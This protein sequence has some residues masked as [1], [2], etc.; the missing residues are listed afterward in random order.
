MK[1]NKMF[2]RINDYN[3]DYVYEQYTR[4]VENFKDYENVSRKKMIEE[5][6]KTYNDYNNII[7]ICTTKEL[8]F[9][10]KLIGSKI[11]NEELLKGKYGWEIDNLCNK[12]ILQFNVPSEGVFIP[13]EIIDKVKEA[14]KNVNWTAK[15]NLDELNEFLIGY[16][17]IQGSVV[18]DMLCSIVSELTD[19]GKDII[20]YHMLT[21]R[22]FR[23]YVYLYDENIVE[24][25]KNVE[26]GIYQDYFYLQDE[27][28]E[29]RKRQGLA[30]TIPMEIELY[31]TIFYNDFDVR[32]KKV[33]KMLDEI[34]KLPFFWFD[35][36]EDIKI[37]ALLNGNR[38]PIKNSIKAVKSLKDYDLTDFFDIL[39]EAMD[40]MP[41]GALNGFTPN[42]AKEKKKEEKKLNDMKEKDYTKQKNACLEQK[43][44]KLFYKIY[45]GL[46]DFTNQIYKIRNNFKIYKQKNINPSMVLD[47]VEEFWKN[48]EKIITEFCLANP[49]KFNDEELSIAG[50]FKKGIRGIYIIVKF[51]EE[52]TAFLNDDKTYMVKG[53]NDNIDNI[54]SYKDLPNA[55]IT[56]IIPFKN[57]LIYD[58]IFRDFNIK[59]GTEFDKMVFEEYSKSIKYYHL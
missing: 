38:N 44:A 1:S 9:L 3:K 11:S 39:D 35:A 51:E 49:Y 25:D 55:V 32:N 31:K 36:L 2:E 54:I 17:K 58:S 30:G 13:D 19:I 6:Y 42:Q 41:S 28:N 10:E 8:K 15:R 53:I 40:E 50:E 47:I 21:D 20:H 45:F 59:M 12:F 27:I 46:L 4:I 52:Y 24:I 56:T 29:A 26:M 23:Y 22:L 7:D 57:V 16:F 18:L 33:K 43:D 34:K 5:I 48:K 14:I 37:C